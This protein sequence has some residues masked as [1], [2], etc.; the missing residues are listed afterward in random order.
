M[1]IKSVFRR[2]PRDRPWLGFSLGAGVFAIAGAARYFFDTLAN[3]FEP[4]A[5]LPAILLAGL[6]G[7]IRVAVGMWLLCIMAAW[8]WFFPPY[9]TFILAPHDAVTM[10]IFVLTAGLELCVIRI[11]N[12]V[13]SDLALAR[14]RS[15]ILFRELQHRV[16]NNLQ[17]AAALLHV[18]KMTLDRDGEG[19]HPIEAARSRLELMSRVHRRLHDPAAV[20]LP[21][22]QYLGDLG[23]DLIAA[24]ALPHIRLQ[25]D[26]AH[27]KLDIDSLISVSLIVAELV[28]NSLKHA[29][30]HSA[31]GCI[32]IR[33]PVV[34]NR[35]FLSVSDDGCGF[36]AAPASKYSVSL[37]QSILRSLA[38]QLR[39]SIS[40]Q[41]KQGATALLVFPIQQSLSP[42]AN[43]SVASWFF[44]I[45]K[46]PEQWK[47]TA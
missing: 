9:G 29:F 35:C 16:A 12:I 42:N 8:V 25:V 27:V 26:V 15:H 30:H 1:A 32:T 22:D 13:I 20:D 4:L 23:R 47:P 44:D 28:T 33:L 31:E 34:E 43:S 11:L 5:L 37:G 24:S 41:W 21:L 46:M 40:F 39:G 19:A 6:F 2:L 36:T 17:F 18:S 10:T 45:A 38:S 7:G 3:G 14:Q